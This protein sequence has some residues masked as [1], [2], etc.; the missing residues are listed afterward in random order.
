MGLFPKTALYFVP[1]QDDELLT[2]GIDICNSIAK[3]WNVHVILCTDGSRSRIRHRL[4]DKKSCSNHA[5][6]H[7]HAL[8]IPEF[9]HA[10]DLEFIASCQALG[11]PRDHIHIPK[12]RA[13][14]GCVRQKDIEDIFLYYLDQFDSDVLVCAIASNNGSGQHSDHKILGTVAETL[15]TQGKIK[16]LRAFIEPYQWRK[17]RDNARGIPVAPY[18]VTA[19]GR[20][21][22][23]IVQA[24]DAY[25]LW[26]PESGRYAVGL[27]SVTTEF[28]DFLKEKR[29]YWY[30]KQL[31][32]QMNRF[33]RIAWR[34]R[35]WLKFHQ[36]KQLF[37]SM[38]PCAAPEL[39]KLELHTFQQRE[40]ELYQNFCVQNSL[41]VREK[42]LERLR[43]G[44]SF[45]CLSLAETGVVSTGWLA[46]KQHFYIGETDFGFSTGRSSCAILYDFNTM[47]Q[48]RGNGYYG[49]LLR[50]IA[51]N[52]VGPSEYLIYTSPD[53]HASD[54]GIRKAGFSFEGT[55]CAADGSLKRCLCKHGFQNIRRKYILYGLFAR[56]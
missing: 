41:P 29:N 38:L 33:E 24:V 5:G 36:Q 6:T 13:V 49:L 40:T 55:L 3:G 32:T 53:N 54:H 31:S 9:I 35:K 2:M 21:A 23:K 7:C 52:A 10:R 51:A 44:S 16:K 4:N 42:D 28:Q 25:S 17:I 20:N 30:Y 19:F 15:L 18:T 34:H 48:H 47:A 43:N 22:Q 45:W 26:A 8:G 11:V 12:N 56:K 39:G 27:H 50:S 46:W 37:Y 14:D 1:H